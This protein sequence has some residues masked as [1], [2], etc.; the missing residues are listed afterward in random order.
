MEDIDKALKFGLGHPMG[1]F[2]LN[3]LT[4][5][6]VGVQ[7]AEVLYSHFKD[8]RWRPFLPLKKL[9]MS[10]DYGK[11]TGKGWYD[12]TSGEKKKRDLNL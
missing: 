5:L 12:Y 11:K 1:P 3:D 2:E 4:G 10:G 7:V 8:P 6:D 9:V